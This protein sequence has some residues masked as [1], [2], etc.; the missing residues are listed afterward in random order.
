ML[1]YYI[2]RKDYMKETARVITIGNANNDA[3]L[4]KRILKYQEEKKLSSAA[5]AVRELCR[6]ALDIKKALK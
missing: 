1:L 5:A 6:D 4:I 3:E 2:R